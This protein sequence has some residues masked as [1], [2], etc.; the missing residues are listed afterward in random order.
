MVFRQLDVELLL[1]LNFCV[2]TFLDFQRKNSNLDEIGAE[3]WIKRSSQNCSNS[4]K[5]GSFR[6]PISCRSSSEVVTGDDDAL[7]AL[8]VVPL[9]RV[10]DGGRHAGREMD[11]VG[12][13]LLRERVLQ[14]GM[15]ERSSSH[16]FPVSSSC[17]VRVEESSHQTAFRQVISGR[18]VPDDAPGRRN[19]VRTEKNVIKI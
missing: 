12:S 1:T 13:D 19:E 10:E 11:G 6:G 3:C 14:A 4:E 15:C 16:D 9:R 7:H 2:K 8:F 18:T 5:V 17:A